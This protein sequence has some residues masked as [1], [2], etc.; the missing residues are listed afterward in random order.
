MEQSVSAASL[1]CDEPISNRKLSSHCTLVTQPPSQ[2]QY[3]EQSSIS[4]KSLVADEGQSRLGG[5]VE[6]QGVGEAV[7]VGGG[8][9]VV[10]GVGVGVGGQCS[11]SRQGLSPQST[12]SGWLQ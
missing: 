2:C 7:G 1:H 3:L 10:V 9:G 4:G 5:N 8:V 11:G 12:S 6:I